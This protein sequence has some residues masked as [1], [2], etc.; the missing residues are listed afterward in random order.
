[1]KLLSFWLMLT[2][3][4]TVA[5]CGDNRKEKSSSGSVTD[6]ILIE[7]PGILKDTLIQLQDVDSIE[8]LVLESYPVQIQAKLKGNYSDGCTGYH[9]HEVQLRDTVFYISLYNA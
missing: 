4:N 1:M 3:I 5:G 7:Q 2:L 8:I 9:H 6:S